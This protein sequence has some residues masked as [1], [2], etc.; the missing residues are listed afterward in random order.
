[1]RPPPTYTPKKRSSQHGRRAQRR[2]RNPRIP[3]GQR[4][5]RSKLTPHREDLRSWFHAEIPYAEIQERLKKRKVAISISAIGSYR[6]RLYREELQET[7]LTRIA[8]GAMARDKVVKEL[9][10]H[11]TADVGTLI[12]LIQNLIFVLTTSSRSAMSVDHVTALLRPVLDW[13]KVQEKREDR[14]LE[15][16]KFAFLQKSKIEIGLDAIEAEVRGNAEAAKVFARLREV[17]RNREAEEK[18]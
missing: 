15:R 11:G 10:I 3:L 8:T 1:M 14:E 5:A 13:V 4:Q 12:A 2:I 9:G 7:V 17:V 16:E 6:Q 18:P